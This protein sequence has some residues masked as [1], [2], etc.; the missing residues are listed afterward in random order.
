VLFAAREKKIQHKLPKNNGD[1]NSPVLIQA[2][3]TQNRERNNQQHTHN[4]LQT[5]NK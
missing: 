4:R 2:N 1:Q 3:K 5:K